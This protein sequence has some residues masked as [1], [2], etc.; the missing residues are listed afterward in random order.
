M[1]PPHFDCDLRHQIRINC[2]AA[3]TVDDASSAV[4]RLYC[5]IRTEV[6]P[7]D[8]YYSQCFQ[9]GQWQCA[10]YSSASLISLTSES[11]ESSV[12]KILSPQFFDL[13]R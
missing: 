10:A 7:S 1:S 12:S 13:L 3:A 6:A 11:D 4:I 5:S 2:N 8:H 9:S